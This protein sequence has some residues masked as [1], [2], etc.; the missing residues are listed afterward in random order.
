MMFNKAVVLISFQEQ[1][2][3]L[4]LRITLRKWIELNWKMYGKEMN[5]YKA[6]FWNSIPF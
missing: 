1:A 5:K 4:L 2:N 6:E 3:L